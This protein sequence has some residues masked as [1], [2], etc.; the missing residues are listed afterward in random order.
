MPEKY[1][2]LYIVMPCFNEQDGILRTIDVVTKKLREL[3]EG[4]WIDEGSA[5]LFADDGSRDNTWELICQAHAN[6]STHVKAIRFAGN[7]G[8]EYALLA[9]VSEAS[10]Q[11]DVII[12]TDADLQF[13]I[14]AVSDFLTKYR[15]GYDLVYGV[16]RNRGKERFYKTIA[17][18]CF[19]GLM[20]KLG[21]PIIPNHTDYCLLSKQVCEALDEY[22]ETNVIFRGMLRSLGFRQC[23]CDFDVK[24]REAGESHFSAWKLINLSL[25]AITSFSVAPLRLIGALGLMIFII[26]LI[27]IVWTISDVFRGITPSGYATLNCSLWFLGGLG[28]LSLSVVGEYIGKLYMEAKKRPRYFIRSRL[29]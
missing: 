28:M 13:D 1:P 9:G 7:R 17:S 19:Y 16:K 29:D 3:H 5:M 12:C 15:E 27:M 2:R 23:S 8:K 21:S 22:G 11:A 24:D 26:G 20:S 18:R 4:G 14:D 25:D 10:K 6:D